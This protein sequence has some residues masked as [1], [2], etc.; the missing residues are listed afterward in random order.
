M[1]KARFWWHVC[2]FHCKTLRIHSS[3]TRK[4]RNLW[5]ISSQRSRSELSRSG[6]L[7][8]VAA[9]LTE[10]WPGK[11][12][13]SALSREMPCRTHLV[14]VWY[15]SLNTLSDN[16][17]SLCFIRGSRE[18]KE[19]SEVTRRC[20]NARRIPTTIDV[21]FEH[22]CC[23]RWQLCRLVRWQVR[24]LVEHLASLVA[25]SWA[26]LDDMTP[27]DPHQSSS[28]QAM[29]RTTSNFVKLTNFRTLDTLLT[30]F[31]PHRI[32]GSSTTLELR[33]EL[34]KLR[35]FR[36]SFRPTRGS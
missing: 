4:D 22:W 2:M 13:T 26:I 10:L 20:G 35:V 16:K 6:Q 34:N 28:G 21:V 9:E 18:P 31:I 27:R 14:R 23:R 25:S 12:S 7:S 11:I 8:L 36:S 33:Q 24:R 15:R 3:M 1:T 5:N 30:L 17:W 32:I 29:T 19:C